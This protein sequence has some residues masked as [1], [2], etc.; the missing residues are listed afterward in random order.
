MRSTAAVLCCGLGLALFGCEDFGTD[1]SEPDSSRDGELITNTWTLYAFQVDGTPMAIPQGQVYA[2]TFENECTIQV[3][4]HCNLCYGSYRLGRR[5]CLT[6]EQLICTKT[7][8]RPPTL[9]GFFQ[10]ALGRVSSYRLETP[11][12]LILIGDNGRTVLSFFQNIR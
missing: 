7:A 3:Q 8:C 12:T 9:D 1:V 5:H 6:I 11:F 4:S 2:V 10:A